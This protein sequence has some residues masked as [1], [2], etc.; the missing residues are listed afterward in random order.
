[1]FEWFWVNEWYIETAMYYVFR[2]SMV[3][4]CVVY[5]IDTVKK[6]TKRRN[7]K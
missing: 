2:I 7:R 1:M 3:T 4:A 5:V 6:W